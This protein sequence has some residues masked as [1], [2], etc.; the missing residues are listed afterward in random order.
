MSELGAS[1]I[2]HLTGLG[3]HYNRF[4][5]LGNSTYYTGNSFGGTVTLLP[6]A[7]GIYANISTHKGKMNIILEDLNKLPMSKIDSRELSIEAGYKS[8]IW[9]VT[10]FTDI[11]RKHGYENIFGDAASGQYPQIGTVAMQ[12]INQKIYGVKGIVDL[13][14]KHTVLSVTPAVCYSHYKEIHRDPKRLLKCDNLTSSMEMKAISV[15]ANKVIV[16]GGIKYNL[17]SPISHDFVNVTTNNDDL[18]NYI[19]I[20]QEGYVTATKTS[21]NFSASI[22]ADLMIGRNKYAVGLDATY[23]RDKLYGNHSLFSASFKF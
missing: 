4:A 5:G 9:G 22:G 20:L 17:I 2:Y 21:H 1:K 23:V 12:I 6:S 11:L 7:G 8:K 13:P 19:S 18:T 14:I 15:I 3:S 10:A 16:R